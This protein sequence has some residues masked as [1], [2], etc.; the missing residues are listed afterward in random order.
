[1][2]KETRIRL[3]CA[4]IGNLKIEPVKDHIIKHIERRFMAPDGNGSL[5]DKLLEGIDEG[6]ELILIFKGK[7]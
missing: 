1:M 6:D 5:L 2:E 7:Q 3:E 4:N